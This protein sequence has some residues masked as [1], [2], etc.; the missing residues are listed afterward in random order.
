MHNRHDELGLQLNML[1]SLGLKSMGVNNEENIPVK[2]D[3][4]RN[5]NEWEIIPITIPTVHTYK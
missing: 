1:S 5:D 3:V 2:M 4:E